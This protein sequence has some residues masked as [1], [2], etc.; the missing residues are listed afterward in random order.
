MRN[1]ITLAEVSAKT[2]TPLATLRYWRATGEG[3]KTFHLGRKV[4]AFESD[5]DA[6]IEAEASKDR[7]QSAAQ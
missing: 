2:R 7:S 3:P 4:V 5:V 1:V 6:W